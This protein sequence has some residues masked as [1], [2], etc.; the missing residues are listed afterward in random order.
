MATITFVG[1]ATQSWGSTSAWSPAQIPTSS[2]L[3]IFTASSGTCSLNVLG[4]CSSIDFTFY[5]KRFTFNTN[6]LW[7]YGNI[8]LGS[9]MNF[10][11]STGGQLVMA[12][13]GTIAPN[14]FTMSA[15]FVLYSNGASNTYTLNNN[16]NCSANFSTSALSGGFT[17]T[18]N[19][20]TISC[21][22]N[23]GINQGS[24]SAPT[25]TTGTT[26][27]IM[28][29]NN[30]TLTSGAST[31]TGGLGNNFTIQTTGTLTLTGVVYYQSG[32]FT[33]L[34]GNM[35]I[36]TLFFT[37]TATF[38]PS[39]STSSNILKLGIQGAGTVTLLSDFYSSNFVGTGGSVPLTLNGYNVYLYGALNPA[40]NTLKGT[41]NI[42]MSGTSSS[43][44][45]Q[46]NMTQAVYNNI[47]INTP[48]TITMTQLIMNANNNTLTYTAGNMNIVGQF[49]IGL[50]AGFIITIATNGMTWGNI[51]V[52][53][54][55]VSLTNQF[56]ATSLVTS[57]S[58]NTAFIGSGGF[59]VNSYSLSN[60]TANF[61]LLLNGGNTY[62]INNSFSLINGLSTGHILQLS[63]IGLTQANLIIGSGATVSVYGQM[64]VTGIN[65]NGGQ[66]VWYYP[67]NVTPT[68]TN[69]WNPLTSFNI[70]DSNITIS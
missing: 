56:N 28:L 29:G 39:G 41:T 44:V 57:A 52:G 8:T 45:G 2:D 32:T 62:Y 12:S 66:P 30:V 7:V 16:L 13:S 38:N 68:N 42:I 9:N 69:N 24:V 20:F 55:T 49:V 53:G 43:S 34:S 11:Y 17:N 36:S 21:Y 4:T 70:Q 40:S 22:S 5:N 51:N 48:G 14:G 33:Y 18:I 35:A 3:V 27:I 23:V 10:T 47:A 26:N 6:S 31:T 37:N 65:S 59:N 61:G 67:T 50:V 25:L 60:P 64:G 58:S 46:L 19:G 15:P 1:S 63:N 54:G